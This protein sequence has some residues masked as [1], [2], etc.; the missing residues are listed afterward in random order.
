[1]FMMMLKFVGV[2]LGYNRATNNNEDMHCEQ[3]RDLP[4]VIFKQEMRFGCRVHRIYSVVRQA[5]IVCM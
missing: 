3:A 1:M 2:Q 5:W 4:K